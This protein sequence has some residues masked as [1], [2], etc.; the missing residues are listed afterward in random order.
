[1]RSEAARIEHRDFKIIV[2]RGPT[3]HDHK[4]FVVLRLEGD[5][6][7]IFPPAVDAALD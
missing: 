6:A 2:N 7:D 5:V 3:D 4:P 1:M